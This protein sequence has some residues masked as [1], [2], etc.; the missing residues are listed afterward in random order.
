[1]SRRSERLENKIN[2]AVST[3]DPD[4]VIRGRKVQRQKQVEKKRSTSVPVH[5]VRALSSTSREGEEETPL[6]V[7]LCPGGNLRVSG[8]NLD[9][10]DSIEWDSSYDK[11]STLKDVSDLLDLTITRVTEQG[12][13][14][15][16]RSES[17]SLNT[18]PAEFAIPNSN[19][20]DLGESV[21]PIPSLLTVP[22]L[23]AVLESCEEEGNEEAVALHTTSDNLEEEEE[24]LARLRNLKNSGMDEGLY[25][26]KVKDLRKLELKILFMLQEFTPEHVTFEDRD[27]YKDKLMSIG[28]KYIKWRDE[29]VDLMADLDP[30]DATDKVRLESVEKKAGEVIKQVADHAK[31]VKEKIT[32]V[33]YSQNLNAPP[34]QAIPAVLDNTSRKKDL[35]NKMRRKAERMETSAKNL[36]KRISELPEPPTMPERDVRKEISVDF[37]EMDKE[38]KEIKESVYDILDNLATV[39]E[40][41]NLRDVASETRLNNLVQQMIEAVT[42]RKVLVRSLDKS[43]GLCTE[44]PNP[45]KSTIPTPDVFEGKVGTNVYKFKEKVLEYIEAAQIREKDKVETLRK[46]L[47]GEAKTRV[48]EHYKNIED[49]LKCLLDNYGNPKV[50]WSESKRMLIEEVGDYNKDWGKLGSQLRVSAIGKCV[51]F[52]REAEL[53]ATEY[54]ELFNS[55]YSP[56][57]FELLTQVLPFVYTDRIFDEIGN[58]RTNDKEKMLVIRDYLEL[59]LQGALVAAASQ[60]DSSITS[61]KARAGFGGAKEYVEGSSRGGAGGRGYGGK[62]NRGGND[63]SY[64]GGK[65]KGDDGHDCAK[66]RRCKVAW[67]LFGCWKLYAC[68]TVSERR[69][70]MRNKKGCWKCGDYP[71]NGFKWH[72][73]SYEKKDAVW[74]IDK[75]C[76]RAAAMCEESH[77][78]KVSQDLKDWLKRNNIKTTVNLAINISGMSMTSDPTNVLLGDITD[79]EVENLQSGVKAKLMPDSELVGYFKKTLAMKGVPKAKIKPYPSGQC[80]FLFCLIEGKTRPIQ[81][82]IDSG[83]NTMLSRQSVPETELVSAKLIK[84][85]IPISVAGGGEVMASGLWASLLPLNDGTNQVAKTLTM[86]TITA[87]MNVVDME[88][89]FDDIKSKSKGIKAVQNLKVPKEV[90]G[91]IDLLIGFNLLAVHP[92]PVHTFPSGLTVY[93]SKFKPP[94]PGVLGCVGGPVEALQCISGMSGNIAALANLKAMAYLTKDYVPRLDFFPNLADMMPTPADPEMKFLNLVEDSTATDC[95]DI[96]DQDDYLEPQDLYGDSQAGH[97]VSREDHADALTSSLLPPSQL[98]SE[99]ET[100]EI[101]TCEDCFYSTITSASHCL[102]ADM[103]LTVGQD[104]R[105]FMEYQEIGLDQ[106]FKCPQCRK[107]KQCQRGAGYEKISMKEEAEQEIIRSSVVLNEEENKAIV[108]LAFIADPVENLKPNKYLALKRLDNVCRKYSNEPKAVDMIC[109]KVAKLQKT[110]HIKYLEDLTVNQREKIEKNPTSHFLCWDVGF[111]EGSLSTPARPV[112]DGSARTPG[113]TSLNEILAKGIISLARLVEVQLVWVMGKIAL[114]GDVSQAYN[115]M[116]LDEDHWAYQ[117]V[118]LRDKLNLLNKVREAIITSAIYGVKCVGGQLEVLCQMLADLCEEEYPE[119]AELLRKFRYV[120]DF[121][122]SENTLQEVLELIHKTEKVLSKASLIVKNWAWSGESPPENMSA[123]GLSVGLAGLVWYTKIDV[124]RLNLDSIHFA[125][126]K[127]GRYPPGTVKYEDTD[128]TMDKYVPENITR[129]NCARVAAR[130]YDLRGDVAPLLL[131]LKYDLRGLILK[132]YDWDDVLDGDSRKRWIE[133]FTMMEKVRQ[134]M[135]YRCKIP[136]DAVTTKGRLWILVDA[137]DGGLVNAAYIGFKRTDGS[138]SCQR[139]FAKGLLCPKLWTIPARELQALATGA[140][141]V[142]FLKNTLAEWLEDDETYVGSDS[143]IALAWVMY[144]KVKLD[145]YHRNRVSQIRSQIEMT[146]LFH[147]DGKF[148]IADTGTRP[149]SLKIEDFCPGSE[150]EKGKEWMKLEIKEA[151]EKGVI[152][153]VDQIKLEDEEKK[154][155]KKGINYE[156]FTTNPMVIAFTAKSKVENSKVE[157]RLEFSRYLYNPLLR[158]FKS[159]VRITAL[160]LKA[161]KCFKKLRIFRLNKNGKMDE[162]ALNEPDTKQIKFTVFNANSVMGHKDAKVCRKLSDLGIIITE[163]DYDAALSYLFKKATEEIYKFVPKKTIEKEGIESEGILYAKTRILEGQELKMMGELDEMLDLESFTGIKFKVPLVEKNSPLAVAIAFH[164]HYNVAAHKGS[165][166]VYRV[167]LQHAKV[168]AGKSLYMAVEEDCV[169]CKILKK[170]YV[171]QMMG[172]LADSQI[173]ISPVFYCSLLDMW[174]PIRTY[175]PGYERT[176]YTRNSVSFAKHYEVYFLVIACVITG[177]V[178]VQVIEKKT[179]EAVLDGLS[180]FFNECSVPK[181]MLPDAD[182]ALM[183]A[184]REGTIELSDLEGT[185][186][187]ENGIIFEECLP[188]GHWEH[189]RVERRIRMLQETLEKSNLKGTRCHASG[190]QTIAKA[191]ERQVNDVPLGLLEQPTRKGNVLRILTPNMLKMNTRNNRAPKGLLTIPGKASDLM[192]NIEK[193]FNLWYQVWNDVYLPMAAEY[194][195]WHHQEDNME[196]GDI[197]MFKLKDSVFSSVWK[198]GK[199]DAVHVG[200]D[201][202]VRGLDISYKLVDPGKNEARHIVVQRPVKQVVKLFNIS[203]TSLLSDITKVRHLTEEIIKKKNE[204]NT[205]KKDETNPVT[206]ELFPGDNEKVDTSPKIQIKPENGKLDEKKE[207]ESIPTKDE[208]I[209]VKIEMKSEHESE[210]EDVEHQ[211]NLNDVPEDPNKTVDNEVEDLDISYPDGQNEEE[212]HDPE[213]TQVE[214]ILNHDNKRRKSEAEKLII[215]NEQFWKNFDERNKRN[216]TTPVWAMDEESNKFSSLTC[217]YAITE[218]GVNVFLKEGSELEEGKVYLL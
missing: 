187:I 116:L 153:H 31:A 52:L 42:E 113:G 103:T 127:R 162:S 51:E 30:N 204:V 183:E 129:R 39:D 64:G 122:K 145:V 22:G 123:D 60:S 78:P 166:T 3:S 8:E 43:L 199:V 14:S 75:D 196:V 57:T 88:G 79:E 176:G 171:E 35:A 63:G 76:K 138:Y 34:A 115:A 77:T 54:P 161:V 86:E 2:K 68:D 218:I 38:C 4:P 110:G 27:S 165:E 117:K 130:V 149:D 186:S 71:C 163:E 170:K 190:L 133:N 132:K 29:S 67:G 45:S 164:I 209:D 15:K 96:D 201:D 172:P 179:T 154:V 58:V 182:G 175:C 70:F 65:L 12:E 17:V 102:C 141:I 23:A 189:G 18:A 140:D 217:D 85:P 41:L 134:F 62:G 120:D 66:D 84:G 93:K 89:V 157:E 207:L 158:S 9:T 121:A 213:E 48:G 212:D 126:K 44:Y 92:E 5:R 25:Q 80:V 173:T 197:V 150:W 210:N 119:V 90:G 28:E 111:K 46:F 19:L 40:E 114:T 95:K 32:E 36:I 125:V 143:R 144:E 188:Q 151:E 74:C 167:S 148:N 139:V 194:K 107:C 56:S 13:T 83:C 91:K 128:K 185:L 20:Y 105:K 214:G 208:S 47:S 160:V 198:I 61:L 49:A 152:K 21:L 99:G 106:G 69:E 216:K 100:K 87:D 169:R 174:G 195:K 147:V 33:V 142:T 101:S 211:D 118:L 205:K 108:K 168:I 112:F 181:V 55:V 6:K 184:L 156:E 7:N 37:Q 178:N 180:R 104:V 131:R 24:L 200:R 146:K 159:V 215:E 137:A 98:L 94:W 203:D 26:Q 202:L 53:L 59:K 16:T 73:C 72:K 135:F 136:Y 97:V 82:F 155:F 124:Y 10:D 191:I 1:M 11:C 193:I 177:A 81:A 206:E 109:E 192:K 50:I